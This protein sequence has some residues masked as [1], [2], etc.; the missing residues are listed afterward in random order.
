MERAVA[1]LYKQGQGD[2]MTGV[3]QLNSPFLYEILSGG[4]CE[5][6][7]NSC[8]LIEL[9]LGWVCNIIERTNSIGCYT[10]L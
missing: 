6:R 8:W 9:T 5:N 3:F 10:F 1:W 2:D 4:Y 7:R